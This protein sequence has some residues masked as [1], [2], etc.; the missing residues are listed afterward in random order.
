MPD[1]DPIAPMNT[2]KQPR[3]ALFVD[4]TSANAPP[5]PAF[6]RLCPP[7][8]ADLPRLL[9]PAQVAVVFGISV[10]AAR[11]DGN[12][13]KLGPFTVIGE[14]KYYQAEEVVRRWHE[15]YGAKPEKSKAN[16]GEQSNSLAHAD[17]LVLRVAAAIER[18]A[19]GGG[20]QGEATATL[21][22]TV[23]AQQQEIKRLTE[24]L[25]TEREKANGAGRTWWARLFGGA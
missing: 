24:A 6:D 14:Q 20:S 3:P 23:E 13:K 16:Q 25:E 10:E 12:R 15:R 19:E 18:I 8:A 7:A 4:T 9:T 5:L 2:S 22:R 11:N 17:D 21:A 1:D